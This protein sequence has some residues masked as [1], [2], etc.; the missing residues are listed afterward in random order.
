LLEGL[1]GSITIGTWLSVIGFLFYYALVLD[2]DTEEDKRKRSRYGWGVKIYIIAVMFF[3]LGTAFYTMT[4][5]DTILFLDY[6]EKNATRIIG[7]LFWAA[8]V[9]WG[10]YFF[11]VRLSK[12]RRTKTE[13]KKE[14]K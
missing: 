11:G 13:E 1:L 4:D 3:S 10:I 2:D 7:M 5:T 14:A 8:T 9:L 12:R 6:L